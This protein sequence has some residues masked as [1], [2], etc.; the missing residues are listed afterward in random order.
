MLYDK[1]GRTYEDSGEAITTAI[2]RFEG[3]TGRLA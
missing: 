2:Q 3:L 1:A